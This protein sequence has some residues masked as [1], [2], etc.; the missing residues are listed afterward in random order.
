V[1]NETKNVPVVLNSELFLAHDAP[2][3]GRAGASADQLRRVADQGDGDVALQ[4][5]M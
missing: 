3:A 4:E 2:L 1:I 5:Q